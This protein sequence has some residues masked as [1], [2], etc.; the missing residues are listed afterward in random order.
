MA[1]CKNY[2]RESIRIGC[3]DLADKIRMT[4]VN[5]RNFRATFDLGVNSS[6]DI[7]IKNPSPSC[8]EIVGSS[9]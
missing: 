9:A 2:H 8:S 3:F 5:N 6:G 7:S 4:K 1:F